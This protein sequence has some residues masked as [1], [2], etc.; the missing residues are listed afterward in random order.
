MSF[1]RLLIYFSGFV[2]G[3]ASGLPSADRLWWV[4]GALG[5]Y[6]VGAMLNEVRP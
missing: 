6:A 3:V 4:V 1:S 5:L 2:S